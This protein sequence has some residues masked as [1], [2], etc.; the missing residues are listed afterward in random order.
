MTKDEF[1]AGIDLPDGVTTEIQ[2]IEQQIVSA[3]ADMEP[4]IQ[5][6]SVTC[7]ISGYDKDICLTAARAVL[8][9]VSG[10]ETHVRVMPEAESQRDFVSGEWKHRGYVRF[11]FFDRPGKLHEPEPL[12]EIKYVGL[13][14]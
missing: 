11:S 10:K 6:N 13:A 4:I 9:S 7:F 12:S 5:A 14:R 1:V 2:Y 3:I 8:N